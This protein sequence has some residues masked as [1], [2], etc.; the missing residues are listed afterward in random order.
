MT[1]H[2]LL[3]GY[4]IVTPLLIIITGVLFDAIRAVRREQRAAS[5]GRHPSRKRG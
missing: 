5:Q 2:L 4:F 1:E 3:A